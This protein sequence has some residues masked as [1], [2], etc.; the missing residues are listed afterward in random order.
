[1]NLSSDFSQLLGYV[2]NQRWTTHPNSSGVDMT[3]NPT[4]LLSLKGGLVIILTTSQ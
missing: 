4:L 3:V 1:M 2:E